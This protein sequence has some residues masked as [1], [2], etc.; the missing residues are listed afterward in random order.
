MRSPA[1]TA[2][3][4]INTRWPY[5]FP[6]RWDGAVPLEA[7]LPRAVLLGE[8]PEVS[9]RWRRSCDGRLDDAAAA[10]LECLWSRHVRWYRST[11]GIPAT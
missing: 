11:Q 7:R 1:P 2:G 10:K 6:V 8:I 4:Q 9:W 5:Q 3:D